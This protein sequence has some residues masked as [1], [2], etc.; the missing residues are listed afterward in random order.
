MDGSKIAALG[1]R[2]R[3]TFE[4]GLAQT[5]AWFREN[6]AWWRAAR[7]GDWHDYYARQ[8]GDRLAGSTEATG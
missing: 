6:E 3:T 2:N 7:S 1:W 4:D 5:V 8:Y